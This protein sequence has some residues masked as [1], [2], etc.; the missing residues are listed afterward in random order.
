[1]KALATIAILF[2]M[3]SVPAAGATNVLDDHDSVGSLRTFIIGYLD[4]HRDTGFDRDRTIKVTIAKASLGPRDPQ[5]YVIYIKSGG[6]CGSGGCHTLFVSNVAGRFEPLGFICCTEMPI[7]IEKPRG[8]SDAEF[9]VSVRNMGHSG[10]VQ[11]TLTRRGDA[12]DFY[13]PQTAAASDGPVATL[14]TER[15]PEE[16]LY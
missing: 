5:G 3:L 9:V 2:A 13:Q 1:M 12:Y 11:A 7:S 4:R 14:I 16:E 6:W 15:T 8:E 10:L